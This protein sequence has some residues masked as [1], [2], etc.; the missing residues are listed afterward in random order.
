MAEHGGRLR[1]A[2]QRYGIALDDWLGLSTGIALYGWPLPAIAA[3]AWTRLPEPDDGLE[4]VAR[5]YYGAASLLPV[6]GSQAV[7]QALPRLR[8]A[9]TVGIVSPTY[10]EH[11]AAWRRCG[12]SRSSR[13]PS[14]RR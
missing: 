3:E 7:I 12:P 6:A 5:D 9:C 10:A 4:A 8:K 2:A 14:T 13:F 1:A 11:A